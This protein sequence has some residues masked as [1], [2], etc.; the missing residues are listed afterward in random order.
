MRLDGRQA[1]AAIRVC[2]RILSH[3]SK[4]VSPGGDIGEVGIK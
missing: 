3:N 1:Q 4:A 2:R